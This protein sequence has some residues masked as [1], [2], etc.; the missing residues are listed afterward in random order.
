[1]QAR[2]LEL[3]LKCY[4]TVLSSTLDK[5]LWMRRYLKQTLQG[6]W[7]AHTMTKPRQTCESQRSK[8]GQHLTNAKHIPCT[9]DLSCI[10]TSADSPSNW[11]SEITTRILTRL[12]IFPFFFTELEVSSKLRSTNEESARKIHTAND[13]PSVSVW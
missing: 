1:M 2:H 12:Y 9:I 4:S 11:D 5:I 8:L 10:S 3:G 6:L 7:D 13:M